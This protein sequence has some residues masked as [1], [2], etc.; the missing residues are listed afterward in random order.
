VRYPPVEQRQLEASHDVAVAVH[1]N[2]VR[3][4]Q[5]VDKAA[6]ARVI[7]VRRE[8]DIVHLHLQ[9]E[10]ASVQRRDRRRLI[11]DGLGQCALHTVARDHHSVVAARDTPEQGEPCGG[12][13][14]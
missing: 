2:D 12:G 6:G 11:H 14:C 8:G 5:E 10:F 13:S 7:T 9:R 4:K 3:G 1:Q